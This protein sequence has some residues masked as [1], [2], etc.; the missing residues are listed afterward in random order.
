MLFRAVSGVGRGM[1]VL[2]GG[3]DRRRESDS[4]GVNLGTSH[5]NNTLLR[6]CTRATR[7]SQ[8]TLGGTCLCLVLA[9]ADSKVQTEPWL[10]P[11]EKLDFTQCHAVT[12]P[13][14]Y[15]AYIG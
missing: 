4:F 3:G 14:A 13:I 7:F 8:I 5:C 15:I 11:N 6:S 12:R 10:R 9:V 1:A 2:D